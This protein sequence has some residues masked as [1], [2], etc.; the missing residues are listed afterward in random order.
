MSNPALKLEKLKVVATD[1]IC[2]GETC[3]SIFWV[4]PG[5]QQEGLRTLETNPLRQQELQEL[6][7]VE[8]ADALLLE[9]SGTS[10]VAC[11]LSISFELPQWRTALELMGGSRSVFFLALQDG[12]QL[13]SNPFLGLIP[14]D[15]PLNL[16]PLPTFFPLIA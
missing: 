4:D 12:K 14:S 15:L 7:W 11:E 3:Y 9:V 8:E 2:K 16:P 5:S 1:R 13:A 6:R 10:P